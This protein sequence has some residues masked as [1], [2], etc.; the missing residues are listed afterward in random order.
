MLLHCPVSTSFS[1]THWMKAPHLSSLKLLP[2]NLSLAVLLSFLFVYFLHF[3]PSWVIYGHVN[4]V[5]ALTLTYS[6]FH[7]GDWCIHI[8]STSVLAWLPNHWS[9]VPPV[10]RCLSEQH[11]RACNPSLCCCGH[12]RNMCPSRERDRE[13]SCTSSVNMF[14]ADLSN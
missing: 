7:F 10:L 13:I 12:P 5:R 14:L 9:I 1:A 8:Y 4:I 6:L 2:F 3:E 11:K